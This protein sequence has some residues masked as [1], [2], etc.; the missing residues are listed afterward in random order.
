MGSCPFGAGPTCTLGSSDYGLRGGAHL[1]GDM[2]WRLETAR[3]RVPSHHSLMR[4]PRAS[5]GG[6][7]LWVCPP[8][9][10]AL[11]EESV[12][13]GVPGGPALWA[14]PSLHPCPECLVHVAPGQGL[15]LRW[16]ERGAGLELV[17]GTKQNQVQGHRGR[18]GG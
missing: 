11:Q 18:A 6:S 15:G 4:K 8:A 2:F 17:S 10:L 13:L 1:L 9:G 12:P 3:P 5:P 7:G 14:A 16:G